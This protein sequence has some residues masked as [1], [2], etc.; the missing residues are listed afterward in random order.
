MKEKKCRDCRYWDEI[1]DSGEK[2]GECRRY[3][4]RGAGG[5]LESYVWNMTKATDWCGDF[6]TL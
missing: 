2:K 6:D 4:P 3:A 1:D 5:G